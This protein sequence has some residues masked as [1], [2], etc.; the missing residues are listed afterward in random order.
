MITDKAVQVAARLIQQEVAREGGGDA[1]LTRDALNP[2]RSSPEERL[3]VQRLLEKWSREGKL[4]SQVTASDLSSL[5]AMLIGMGPLDPLIEDRSVISINVLGPQ[6]VQ[7]QRGG[8]WEPALVQGRAVSWPDAEALHT[9]AIA[10]A[11]RTGQTLEQEHPVIQAH[12]SAPIAGRLQIDTTARTPA[13]VSIHI[14]LG[15]SVP[16]TLPQM[17]ADGGL[18][19]E[20]FE[21]LRGIAQRDIGVLIV[22][23]PG[24][25]K[26][27]FMEACMDYWPLVPALA[28]DD[29]SE[30]YPRHP[31][32]TTYDVPP[33]RLRGSFVDAL[34][35]NVTRVAVAEVR[36][37]EAAEML[38]YSGA[39]T[40]WGTLHGN[41]TNAVLRLV[42]LVQGAPDS[43]YAGL[44]PQLVK[45]VIAQA[46]PVIIE[47]DRLVVGGRGI[48]FISQIAE[49]REG[50]DAVPLFSTDVDGPRIKSFS[51]HGRAGNFLTRY[52]R[53]VWGGA[54]LPQLGTLSNLQQDPT[55]PPTVSLAAV[56]EYLR[57]F[58]D[59]KDAIALLKAVMGQPGIREM[60]HQALTQYQGDVKSALNERDWE[61]LLRLYSALEADPVALAVAIEAAKMPTLQPLVKD[62]VARRARLCAEARDILGLA[63]DSRQILALIGLLERIERDPA[64]YPPVMR[65]EARK[66]LETLNAPPLPDL[67]LHLRGLA[68]RK[69]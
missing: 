53:R 20:M 38:R 50:G 66:R 18:S 13:G 43:P 36:G 34:R 15:R 52:R 28:L 68:R 49:L 58:P 59:N 19:A 10:L 69:E 31:Q 22:G 37:D 41:V 46:F 2:F 62:E 40:I 4:D 64:I 35:K 11:A 5:T 54:E 57:A 29:R 45:E 42:A 7:V 51:N 25:G 67:P 8:V 16:I 48:Y 17:V 47:M 23:A 30:F 39:L 9:F 65:H 14:R 27:T 60:L 21:F 61:R 24:T 12:F 32:I 63:T 33:E 6:Q 56:G 3:K 44:P 1:R 55:L 26:T